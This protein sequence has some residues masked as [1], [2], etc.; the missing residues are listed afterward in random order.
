MGRAG[1]FDAIG[2]GERGC[3]PIVAAEFQRHGVLAPEA[4][5]AWLRRVIV[6]LA[7]VRDRVVVAMAAL[8]G[9]MP[10]GGQ[11]GE[12]QQQE[13][14]PHTSGKYASRTWH[15]QGQ[16]LRKLFSIQMVF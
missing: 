15:R 7:S 10:S 3:R 5:A 6:R 16:P 2:D 13:R 9:A 4:I 11:P 1:W 14:G 8:G 12:R